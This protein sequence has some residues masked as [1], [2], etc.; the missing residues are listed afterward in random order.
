MAAWY[1]Y[2]H[3]C[4]RDTKVALSL[5]YTRTLVLSSL[6]NFTFLFF[7]ATLIVKTHPLHYPNSSSVIQFLIYTFL[8]V[9]FFFFFTNR[10][11]FPRFIIMQTTPTRG[12]SFFLFL[13]LFSK[14][15]LLMFIFASTQSVYYSNMRS[16]RATTTYANYKQLV[17]PRQDRT[18]CLFYAL[19]FFNFATTRA[20]AEI[21]WPATWCT[22]RAT[23]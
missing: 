11:T 7:R 15:P 16:L 10:G 23:I 9:R 3:T 21:K 4:Y 14:P 12:A 22:I 1:N 18:V 13:V 2:L 20:I 6:A 19:V 5:K 17:F 8:F